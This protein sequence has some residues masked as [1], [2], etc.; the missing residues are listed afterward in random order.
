[1]TYGRQVPLNF[2][3]NRLE[4]KNFS[5]LGVVRPLFQNF[6]QRPEERPVGCHRTRISENWYKNAEVAA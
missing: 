3:E 5:F 2:G 6:H 4:N 1:M